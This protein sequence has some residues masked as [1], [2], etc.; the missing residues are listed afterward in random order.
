[1]F[2]SKHVNYHC[3]TEVNIKGDVQGLSVSRGPEDG[4][5]I[6]IEFAEIY[7]NSTDVPRAI[8][9]RFMISPDQAKWLAK[10]LKKQRKKL[11]EENK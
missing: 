3:S 5:A 1:M 2:A 4:G 10:E 9:H 7:G 11:L 6:S 8:M